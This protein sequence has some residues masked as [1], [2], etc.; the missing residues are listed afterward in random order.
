MLEVEDFL[1]NMNVSFVERRYEEIKNDICNKTFM[2]VEKVML[3]LYA[4]CLSLEVLAVVA[5]V[6]S[7]RLNRRQKRLYESEERLTRVDVW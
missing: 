7:V 4:L 6:L 1:C 5:H 3:G 2:G